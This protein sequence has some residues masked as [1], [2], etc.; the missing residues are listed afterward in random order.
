MPKK[1]QFTEKSAYQVKV[2]IIMQKK[3][4]ADNL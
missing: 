1:T 4:H 3:P 2:Y